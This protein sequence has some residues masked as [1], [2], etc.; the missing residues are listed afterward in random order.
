M[1]VKVWEMGI[2]LTVFQHMDACAYVHVPFSDR[3]GLLNGYSIAVWLS[4]KQ[5][6]KGMR[7]VVNFSLHS[8]TST[9]GELCKH[10]KLL[11]NCASPKSPGASHALC[12]SGIV[13]LHSEKTCF[14]RLVSLAHEHKLQDVLT[15]ASH[16]HGHLVSSYGP[17]V[18]EH[19]ECIL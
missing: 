17:I 6:L 2:S 4:V 15:N 18:L 8:H 16:L 19:S 5:A 9:Y 14:I 10:K 3:V 11:R 1:P 12:S 13:T 7:W